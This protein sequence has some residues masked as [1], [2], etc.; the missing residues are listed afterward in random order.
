LYERKASFGREHKEN[1]KAV[2]L[3]DNAQF[4]LTCDE[5]T[6]LKIWSL[7]GQVIETIDTKQMKNNCMAISPGSRF[8]AVGAFLPDVKVLL[9]FYFII[10]TIYI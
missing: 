10:E 2:L 6:M 9:L 4:I 3:A 8:F 1:L 5:A 7:K